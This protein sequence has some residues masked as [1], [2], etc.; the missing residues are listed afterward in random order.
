MSIFTGT[1]LGFLSGLGTGG[2]SLL[3]LWLTLGLGWTSETARLVNLM[4]FIPAAIIACCFRCS[5]GHLSIRKVLPGMIAASF[6][7]LLF[8]FLAKTID[9]W[10]IKKLLGI[11]LLFTGF[12][13]LFYREQKRK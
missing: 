1:L 7:A 10:W 5:Q 11:L 4:F 8:S 3:I 6:S 13:E 2:G 9:P 12:R